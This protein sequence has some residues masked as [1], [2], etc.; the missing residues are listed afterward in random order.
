MPRYLALSWNASEANGVVASP[1]GNRLLVEQVFTI[2]LAGGPSP[3]DAGEGSFSNRLAAEL[4]SRRLGRID[5][6]VAL[7]RESVELRPLALPAAPDEELPDLARFQALRQFSNLEEHWPLDYLPLSV[8]DDTARHVLAAAVRPELVQEVQHVCEA[9]GLKL[10]RLVLRPCATVSLVARCLGER[11]AGARLVVNLEADETDLAVMIDSHVTF[12][13]QARL[14]ADP[15]ADVEHAASLVAEL[16]RTMAAAQNQPGNRPVD[17]I[18][19]LGSG[20]RYTRLAAR[21]SE[22]WSLAVDVVDPFEAID[23]SSRA[24]AEQQGSIRTLAPLVGA[25]WDEAASAA[26]TFDF[27]HPRRRPAPPSRRNTYAL[28]GL[29][30]GLLVLAV[31]AA[32]WI[33]GDRMHSEILYLQRNSKALD[34]NFEQAE[35]SEKEAAEIDQWVAGGV[36]WLDELRWLSDRFPTAEDAMLTQ[37][38]FVVNSGRGEITLDGVASDVD[39]VAELDR[40]LHDDRHRL[41][42]KSKSETDARRP[43]GMQFRSS[44]RIERQQ[45]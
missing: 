7:G 25:A 15:L 10:T 29:A 22:G 6:V 39:S 43:Y 32:S 8:P 11:N 2:P 19:L 28:A 44:V 40:G 45:Q 27:L 21:I 31:M 42:G 35:K 24:A 18:V 36:N 17:S 1:G 20:D 30:A 33:R 37:V 14:P 23:W 26:P 41:A 34:K 5:T 13:R 16:R 38:K 9:A 12:L 3:G 4:K